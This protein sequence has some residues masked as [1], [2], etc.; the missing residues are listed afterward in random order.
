RAASYG[1][2]VVIAEGGR[3]GGTCVLRGCI[4]KKL[5]VYASHFGD[6][7]AVGGSYGWD[8]PA[9]TFSWSKLK[10]RRD[11]VVAGL[12]ANH[13]RSLETAGVAL[14][15]GR[16]RLVEADTVEVGG[17]RYRARHILVATGGRPSLPQV[18]GIEHCITS[19]DFFE[20]PAAPK[21][22]LVVGGGY[23]AVE[24]A[25]IFNALGCRTT[26]W[27]RSAVLRGFDKDIR[28][29]LVRAMGRQGISVEEGVDL[30]DVHREAG[31]LQVRGRGE[32]GERACEVDTCLVA[33]GRTPSTGGLG[34]AEVG[35]QLTEGGAVRVD[36]DHTT[37]VPTLHAVGDVIDR[38]NLTPVAIKASRTLADRL[39]GGKPDARMSYETVATAVFGQPEVAVVGLTEEEARTRLGDR[40]RA[41]KARFV[42]LLYSMV[43]ADQKVHS[44]MKLVVDGDTDRV[45]GFHMLGDG[46]AEIIQGF[47]ACLSA[48]ITKAQLDAT[49][50]IHPSQAEE[51]VLMR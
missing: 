2:R 32:A 1:A 27:V 28:T 7:H 17:A 46:A 49:F 3:V 20:L 45:L 31:G 4:P 11:A 40:V 43:P 51:F 10:A 38:V 29:E 39:F 47:A 48:G 9:P 23:I 6:S 50:A 41:Y 21:R 15:A 22:A 5:M 18:P 33:V 37:A 26:L 30:R 34:L 19:D 13:R 8:G 24:L 35:V 12:E 25:C 16:A 42:P 36:G 44:L 14:V